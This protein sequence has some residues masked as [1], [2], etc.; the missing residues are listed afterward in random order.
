MHKVPLYYSN[1]HKQE[2]TFISYELVQ[3][4]LS[5]VMLHVGLGRFVNVTDYKNMIC[6]TCFS[7]LQ[8]SM[9]ASSQ[10]QLWA[11]KMQVAQGTLA[12]RKMPTAHRKPLEK[13]ASHCKNRTLSDRG[14]T[15][16]V[17]VNLLTC[18]VPIGTWTVKLKD[19]VYTMN[20]PPLYHIASIHIYR[21]DLCTMFTPVGS[22][23][24][25]FTWPAHVFEL[26]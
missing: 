18:K 14:L 3:V 4:M 12:K 20:G 19:A 16:R 10:S 7:A 17:A 24:F 13:D 6:I 9:A 2:R 1:W 22:R 21:Q 25:Y 23:C 8:W 5:N 26:W 11:S 15:D